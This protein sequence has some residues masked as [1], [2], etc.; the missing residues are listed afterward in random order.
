MNDPY[1]HKDYCHE[2]KSLSLFPE[3]LLTVASFSRGK[4]LKG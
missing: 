3:D 4:L 1:S 2:F